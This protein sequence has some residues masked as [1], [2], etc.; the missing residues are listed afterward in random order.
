MEDQNLKINIITNQENAHRKEIKRP[1]E[2]TALAILYF[3][4]TPFV[5]ADSLSLSSKAEVFNF[6]MSIFII[7]VAFN[8]LKGK[9]WSI[10][11]SIVIIILNLIN[12]I[13]LG[14]FNEIHLVIFLIV[15]WAQFVCF[16]HPFYNQE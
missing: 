12:L 5:I 11:T 9:N 4:V 6:I 15:G 13:Y 7:F 10:L 1:R 3:I 2:G 14:T 16:N 8:I